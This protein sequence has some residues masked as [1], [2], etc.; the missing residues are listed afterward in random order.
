M[1]HTCQPIT[2]RILS[3]PSLARQLCF[4][5]LPSE[6]HW[7]ALSALLRHHLCFR[8][9]PRIRLLSKGK[10]HSLSQRGSGANRQKSSPETFAKEGTKSCCPS[11]GQRSL[12]ENC[13][14]GGDVF[15][16]LLVFRAHQE[17]F[18]L[19]LALEKR[20]QPCLL[21]TQQLPCW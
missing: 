19:L 10:L 12:G 20:K 13:E 3:G 2:T 14:K 21:R 4:G 18:Q 15:P 8:S 11:H 5:L 16:S 7:S 17:E 6:L 1:L 9:S